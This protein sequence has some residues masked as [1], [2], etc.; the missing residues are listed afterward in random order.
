MH[1][2]ILYKENAMSLNKSNEEANNITPLAAMLIKCRKTKGLRQI[3]VAELTG[4]KR[5][6]L[7]AYEKG[8]ILPPPEKLRRLAAVYGINA[9][10]LMKETVQPDNISEIKA[11]S[12]MVQSSPQEQKQLK[13]FLKYYN[14]LEEKYKIAVFNVVKSLYTDSV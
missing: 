7:A 1:K 4:I 14:K 5:V 2:L 11:K 10:E 6:T 12:V 13:D 9:A 3:D 8:R